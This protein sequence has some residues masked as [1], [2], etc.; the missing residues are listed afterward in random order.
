MG[1]QVLGSL[2]DPG[3]V[4]DA[5]LVAVGQDRGDRQPRRIAERLRLTGEMPGF[6]DRDS[7]AAK[8]FR[9]RQIETQQ[10]AA[11]LS[12]RESS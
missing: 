8:R 9:L 4:A 6:G 2:E 3:E 11:I 5:E 12:D 7:V 10:V 1:D